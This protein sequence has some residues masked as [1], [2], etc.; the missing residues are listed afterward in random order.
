ML[1]TRRWKYKYSQR[2]ERFLFIVWRE[3][4]GSCNA[5][6]ASAQVDALLAEYDREAAPS[7]APTQVQLDLDV[8]HAVVMEQDSTVRLLADLRLVST[9]VL[10]RVTSTRPK[11]SRY[12][13]T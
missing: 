6:W 11:V 10:R 5:S 12:L 3:A 8:R 1:A 7:P 4:S 13:L 9:A 2:Y